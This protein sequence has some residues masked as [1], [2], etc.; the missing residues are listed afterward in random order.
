MRSSRVTRWI[1]VTATAAAFA[2]SVLVSGGTTAS[3]AGA[4]S[5]AQDVA[6][7]AAVGTTFQPDDFNWY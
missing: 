1:V 2:L 5:A 6:S 4:A 3:A 7:V